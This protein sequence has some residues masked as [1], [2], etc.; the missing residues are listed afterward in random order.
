MRRKQT[1]QHNRKMREVATKAPALERPPS[2]FFSGVELLESHIWR[3]RKGHETETG[4][5]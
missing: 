2:S 3:Y 1:A 4:L 5:T